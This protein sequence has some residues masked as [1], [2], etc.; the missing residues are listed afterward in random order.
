MPIGWFVRDLPRFDILVLEGVMIIVILFVDKPCSPFFL[1]IV[2]TGNV[3][4]NGIDRPT[5]IGSIRRDGRVVNNGDW[6]RSGVGPGVGSRK[7]RRLPPS[8]GVG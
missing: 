2:C 3:S 1:G 4:I 6:A 7:R 5:R 8:N